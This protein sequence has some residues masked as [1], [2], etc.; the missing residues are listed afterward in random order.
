VTLEGERK[1]YL[2][3]PPEEFVYKSID[4]RHCQPSLYAFFDRECAL[5][6]NGLA[7]RRV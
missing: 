3:L 7:A 2:E 4:E 6:G 5:S 1:V